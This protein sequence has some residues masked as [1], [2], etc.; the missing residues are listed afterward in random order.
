M[1]AKIKIHISPGFTL[2]ELL[3]VIS[4]I[5]LL[6]STVL[7]SLNN[8]RSK[9]RD[10]KR[11]A[12]IRTIRNAVDLY[13]NTNNTFPLSTNPNHGPWL[14]P[15]V[16]ILRTESSD[17]LVGSQ[18][19]I[20]P[21]S[22]LQTEI[23]SFITGTIQDPSNQ[24]AKTYLYVVFTNVNGNPVD[25]YAKRTGPTTCNVGTDPSNG[26]TKLSGYIAAYT[27]ENTSSIVSDDG[28]CF[29]SPNSR[30]EFFSR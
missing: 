3:V 6:A 22:N 12:E 14:L 28:A 9:A 16:Y 11:I 25:I 18:P 1:A 10:A 20:I 27:L 4:V 13:Y 30:V 7:F 5:G 15:N 26:G 24:G 17:W 19:F 2:I 23:A 29:V 21:W 8:A